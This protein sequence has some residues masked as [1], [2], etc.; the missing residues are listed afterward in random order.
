[1]KLRQRA[2]YYIAI[3]VDPSIAQVAYVPEVDGVYKTANAGK[4][5]SPLSPPHG[6]NHIVWI[7]PSIRRSCSSE[8]MA[9]G[10]SPLMAAKPGAAN[11]TNPPGNSIT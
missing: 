4:T 6:D 10:R 9:E 11:A 2:F 3:F 8:M 1:M 5:F 7:N